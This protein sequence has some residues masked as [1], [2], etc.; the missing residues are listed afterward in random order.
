MK[1]YDEG[2]QDSPHLRASPGG[3]ASLGQS[4]TN[5]DTS[6]S[7]RDKRRSIN[8]ATALVY[9]SSVYEHFSTLTKSPGENAA[10]SRDAKALNGRDSPHPAS[11]L[12][13]TFVPEQGSPA[14]SPIPA[15]V[16]HSS[17]PTAS[18]IVHQPI[19]PGRSRSASA[20]TYLAELES[21]PRPSL[22]L[23]HPP[24]RTTSRP[25]YQ[26]PDKPSV[27]QLQS[28]SPSFPPKKDQKPNGTGRRLERP[29]SLDLRQRS[30]DERRGGPG[31]R[32]S[33]SSFATFGKDLDQLP[34]THTPT[35]PAHFVDVPHG[36]ESETDT[37][38]ESEE[39]HIIGYSATPDED[40]VPPALPPKEPTASS[41]RP[42]LLRVDTNDISAERSFS[43]SG[44]P[45]SEDGTSEMS[46]ESSPVEKTSH[47]TFIA[48][49]LP[50][51]RF[52]VT[53]SDFSDLLKTVGSGNGL[54][55]LGLL[56]ETNQEKTRPQ[57][58]DMLMPSPSPTIQS[59]DGSKRPMT[60]TSDITIIGSPDPAVDETPVKRRNGVRNGNAHNQHSDVDHSLSRDGGSSASA[61]S[62]SSPDDGLRAFA[63]P[64][65]G[66]A[67][68][69]DGLSIDS[70]S[71]SS[72]SMDNSHQLKRSRSTSQQTG[73]S[74]SAQD[75]RPSLD[76]KLTHNARPSWDSNRPTTTTATHRGPLYSATGGEESGE[77]HR[78][79][80]I[81]ITAPEPS[82]GPKASDASELVK[83]RLQ[84][85]VVVA[86]ERGSSH[87]R[88]DVEFVDAILKVLNQR[89]EEYNDLKR[90]LDG[91]KVITHFLSSFF[92]S[93]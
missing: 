63:L 80:H 47:A 83:Q 42:P 58:I 15:I 81:T 20:S 29:P 78:S 51:M 18:L 19:I 5:Y 66:M 53:P 4:L 87:V 52:S 90:K 55:S 43:D 49:A 93:F 75:G 8:P 36:I 79:T 62:L 38:A 3:G 9:T 60:P 30:Y 41:M 64:R 27:E 89:K 12:R 39:V 70:N 11:P 61:S 57:R 88:L 77:S 13:D 25:D 6:T 35:S 26:S 69:V 46:P 34:R 28:A 7:R 33:K 74:Q 73:R 59:F 85:A 40:D 23:E 21:F 54:T 50:P 37:E 44:H 31:S 14:S 56:E 86:V 65:R 22:S 67:L 82:P 72:H 10:S 1:S 24:P 76:S 71:D 91:L 68:D 2:A 17:P 84:E 16:S 48:P 32:G 45:D 92:L